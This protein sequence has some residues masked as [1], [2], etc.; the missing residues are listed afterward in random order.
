[1]SLTGAEYAQSREKRR[2]DIAGSLAIAGVASVPLLLPMWGATS[3]EHGVVN[4]LFVQQRVGKQGR[5]FD[6]YKLRTLAEHDREEVQ[7]GGAHHP[8]AS[9]M[10]RLVRAAGLDEFPQ[11]LNVLKGDISLVGIRPLIQ[12]QI[13]IYRGMV[14][15]DLFKEWQ[16]CYRQNPGLTGKGQLYSKAFPFHDADVI[17]RRMEIDVDAF[18]HASLASD[19]EILRYTPRVLLQAAF[20]Q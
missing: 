4:P 18:Y 8:H 13:D 2:L 1:M 5:P 12:D 10:G 16:E 15:E 6:T 14:G 11:L 17:R 20:E 9:L 3:I 19:I 7:E